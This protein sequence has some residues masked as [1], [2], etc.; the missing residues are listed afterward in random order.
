MNFYHAMLCYCGVCCGPMSKKLKSVKIQNGFTFL[1]PTYPGC[2]VFA[3]ERILKMANFW[4]NYGKGGRLSHRLGF[5]LKD[6]N[7]LI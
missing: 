6:E 3:G 4:Q 1:V 5:W 2:V 7:S